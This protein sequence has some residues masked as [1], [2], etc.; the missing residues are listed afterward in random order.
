[1][2]TKYCPIHKH[3]ITRDNVQFC[4]ECGTAL[5]TVDKCKHCEHEVYPSD[6]FCEFCGRPLK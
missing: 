4:S 3:P 6:K 1:M 5:V 2:E